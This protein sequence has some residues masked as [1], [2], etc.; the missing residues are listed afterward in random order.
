M[1]TIGS[2]T[3][4]ASPPREHPIESTIAAAQRGDAAA[5]AALHDRYA[6][7]VHAICLRMAGD[8]VLA[9]ELV[10]D[11]FVRVWERLGSFRGESAFGTWLHR[12][13]VNVV[14]SR[15]R[16]E[17]R[18]RARVVPGEELAPSRI[19]HPGRGRDPGLRL[20]LE[21]AVS[22]LPTI[23][24]EVFVLHD[25]EGFPHGEIAELL[26]IPVGTCRSHLFRARRTLREALG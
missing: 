10:Q 13:A 2:L 17:G 16:A 14:L 12:L 11:V 20:D 25:V 15:R 1:A 18:R 8:P 6:G 5:F 26:R 4:T 22:A 24:R 7:R 21:R 9:G 19:D 3:L 23:L